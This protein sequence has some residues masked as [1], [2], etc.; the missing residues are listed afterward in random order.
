MLQ[1]IIP[2]QQST[3]EKLNLE[4]N[5]LKEELEIQ[6]P[7]DTIVFSDRGLAISKSLKNN[8]KM[9]Q[10]NKLLVVE[11]DSITQEV[12]SLFLQDL[13][14]LDYAATASE[15]IEKISRNSYMAVLMDINL[16]K[17]KNGLH[18][19]AEIR[20]MKGKEKLPIIAQTAFAMKGDREDF[21][22]AGCDYYLSK[23]FTKEELREILEE[24]KYK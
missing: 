9:L 23:P 13:Y 14:E 3:A 11:D 1:N 10:N 6:Y 4:T 12:L 24:I 7:V 2:E 15:A 8:N 19:T 18:V 16:G 17:G 20:R 21:L 5:F 22:S